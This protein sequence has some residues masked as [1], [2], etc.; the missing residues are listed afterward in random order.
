MGCTSS[1]QTV[2]EVKQKKLSSNSSEI[3]QRRT[4][5]ASTSGDLYAGDSYRDDE[6]ADEGPTEFTLH[7]GGREAHFMPHQE[8]NKKKTIVV[9]TRISTPM[10]YYIPHKQRTDSDRIEMVLGLTDFLEEESVE[11]EACP[12]Y[13]FT[14]KEDT[15]E[16]QIATMLNDFNKFMKTELVTSM[17]SMSTGSFLS[18]S[19]FCSCCP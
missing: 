11:D 10:K 9:K 6:V 19:K 2:Q 7:N 12:I 13:D 16:F 17:H 14:R 1:T 8:I 18:K 3:T 15:E 5:V 4:E